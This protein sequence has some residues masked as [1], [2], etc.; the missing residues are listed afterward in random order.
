MTVIRYRVIILSNYQVQIPLS[1]FIILNYS[2]LN[3]P[4]TC[5]VE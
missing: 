5:M 1:L 3:K 4:P 2:P